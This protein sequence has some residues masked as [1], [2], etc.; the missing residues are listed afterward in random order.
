MEESIEKN[1][2]ISEGSSEE[3][4]EISSSQVKASRSSVLS[5]NPLSTSHHISTTSQVFERFEGIDIRQSTLHG[6]VET[7]RERRDL[8]DNGVEQM[9]VKKNM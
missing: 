2:K 9:L 3:E 6:I 8:T 5:L 1:V 4:K 7:L